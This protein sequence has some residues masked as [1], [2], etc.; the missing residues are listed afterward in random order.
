M[1]ELCAK[2]GDTW[3]NHPTNNCKEFQRQV[4]EMGYGFLKPK[5][6][7]KLHDETPHVCGVNWICPECQNQ[8]QSARVTEPASTRV[9]EASEDFS[10]TGNLSSGVDDS[11]KTPDELE[12]Q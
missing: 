12:M 10:I 9:G 11:H 8:S 5:G 7:G 1:S 6:C 4:S 2:C 3:D